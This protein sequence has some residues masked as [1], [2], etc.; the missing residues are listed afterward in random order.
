[1]TNSIDQFADHCTTINGM[2][3]LPTS[4]NALTDLFFT[5]GSSRGCDITESF[6]AAFCEDPILATKIA[7]WARDVRGGA[8][9]RTIGRDVFRLLEKRA[10]DILSMIMDKIPMLGRIDDLLIFETDEFQTKAFE[11]I[12]R[13]LEAGNK[14]CGK[15]LPREKSAN[16]RMA[17]K[18]RAYLGLSPKQYRKLLVDNTDVVETNMCANQWASIEFSKVPSVAASRY[19]LAF[20]RHAPEEYKQYRD[21][22]VSGETKVNAGALYPYDIIKA[23]KHGGD[24]VVSSAQWEAL[25]NYIGDANIFPVV[26]VSGSMESLVGSNTNLQCVDVAVSL[27]L[28]CSEKVSGPFRDHFI[29]FS[30]RPTMVELHGN[31]IERYQQL[32]QADWGYSTN[33]E[34]IFKLLF[35]FIVDHE[36]A[37]HE[38]PNIL[39]ILSDMQFD[40]ATTSNYTAFEM[41]Q[42]KFEKAGYPMPMIV[43]WNLSSYDTVPVSF[44]N[45]GTAMVSGFSP[46]IMKSVL[47]AE[48]FTPVD[49]MMDT[50][51]DPRYAF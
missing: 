35:D 6:E 24:E 49:I 39:L 11:I 13:E 51:N 40:Q 7:L 17:T 33:L 21:G 22:L 45:K 19:Q 2:A 10:P 1:M 31:L 9:E 18:L 15:W 41:I 44:D 14:L 28:Y 8:G 48:R 43:F 27:G 12:K 25:P 36:V 23:I 16:K 32:G 42:D 5:I 34:A 30:E 38:I 4:G 29:T 47:R 37:R 26:D 20:N 50:I 46:V 3:A